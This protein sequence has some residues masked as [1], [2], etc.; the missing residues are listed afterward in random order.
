MMDERSV[1]TMAYKLRAPGQK[2]IHYS[3]WG[4]F[5]GQVFLRSV[6]RAEELYQAMIIRGYDGNFQYATVE[7]W[8]KSDVLY[9]GISVVL[10]VAISVYDISEIVGQMIL[11]FWRH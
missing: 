10:I 7:R 2:G 3:A 9:I 4:S 1:M 11:F 6:G 8:K 5:L